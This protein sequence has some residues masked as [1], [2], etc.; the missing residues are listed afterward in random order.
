MF[1]KV[2]KNTIFNVVEQLVVYCHH[3]NVLMVTS[4]TIIVYIM[5]LLK[6]SNIMH[7]KIKA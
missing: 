5:S 3:L 2:D 1:N 6:N 4:I 7:F